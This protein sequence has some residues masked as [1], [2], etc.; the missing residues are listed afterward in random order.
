MSSTYEKPLK[1]IDFTETGKVFLTYRD[2]ALYFTKYIRSF[3]TLD[4][5]MKMN[6][7]TMPEDQQKTYAPVIIWGTPQRAYASIVSP[8]LNGQLASFGISI[9][10]SQI[11]FVEDNNATKFL[12]E[13]I[14]LERINPQTNEKE[15]LKA[16]LTRPA[17]FN[18][19]FNLDMFAYSE[20]D[21]EELQFRWRYEFNNNGISYIDVYNIRSVLS[22]ENESWDNN[23]NLEPQ[24]ETKGWIRLTTNVKLMYAYFP[25]GIYNVDYSNKQITKINL[26]INE[27]NSDINYVNKLIEE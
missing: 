12:L 24:L 22:W 11:E 1:A 15:R 21:A 27:L 10:Y 26:S 25:S 2:Y 5:L 6:I 9:R 20:R 8:M 7:E 13:P 19:I 4:R 23:T 16:N 3:M 18:A 14:K 17:C